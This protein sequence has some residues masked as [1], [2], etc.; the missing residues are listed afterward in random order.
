[1][2]KYDLEVRDRQGERRDGIGGKKGKVVYKDVSRSRVGE[3]L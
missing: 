1:M 2:V 3:E